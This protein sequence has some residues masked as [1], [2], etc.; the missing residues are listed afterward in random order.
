MLPDLYLPFLSPFISILN[1]TLKHSKS[2]NSKP[3]F[4]HLTRSL[5][6]WGLDKIIYQKGP[7]LEV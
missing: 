1:I 3:N 6:K 5:K 2:L 4:K 7:H